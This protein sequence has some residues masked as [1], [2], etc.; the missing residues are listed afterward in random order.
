MKKFKKKK[1]QAV[2]LIICMTVS[3]FVWGGVKQEVYAADAVQAD[4]SGLLGSVNLEG[5][6]Y[7]EIEPGKMQLVEWTNKIPYMSTVEIPETVEFA[8]K[9]Y[10][11]VSIGDRAFYDQ[12]NMAGIIFPDTILSIGESAFESCTRLGQLELPSGLK[13]IGRRAFYYCFYLSDEVSELVIPASVT[14][15]GMSAFSYCIG[16]ESVTILNPDIRY[17]GYE[18]S[19]TSSLVH[20]TLPDG[21]TSLGSLEQGYM[22]SGCKNLTSI[23][24]PESLTTIPKGS[25]KNCAGLTEIS[26]PSSVNSLGASV[27]MGCSGL[28]EVVIPEGVTDINSQ[29]FCQCSEEL[30]VIFPDSVTSVNKWTFWENSAQQQQYSTTITAKCTSREVAA[31]IA[32]IGHKNILLNGEPYELDEFTT[33]QFKFLVVDKENKIVQIEKKAGVSLSGEIVIPKTVEWEGNVYTVTSVASNGFWCADM[34]KIT[35]PD[36][37]TSIGKNAFMSCSNL[38]SINLPDGI[39]RIDQ[40]TFDACPALKDITLPSN[41]KYIDSFAFKECKSLQTIEIPESCTVIDEAA[42][43]GCTGLTEVTL[44]EGLTEIGNNVFRG[45]TGLTGISFP[46]SLE[47]LGTW[48]FSSCTELSEVV[49]NQGLK[50]IG[51]EIFE[52][53][54]KLTGTMVLPDSVTTIQ[55]NAFAKSSLTEVRVGE[56]LTLLES[57]AF[58]NSIRRLTTYSPEVYNLLVRNTNRTGEYAPVL[59]WDGKHD[60]PSGMHAYAEEDV[61]VTE[62][63]TIK[64]GAIVTVKPGVSVTIAEDAALTVEEGGRLEI[65]E[66]ASVTVN[67]KLVN[68]GMVAV[69]GGLTVNGTLANNGMVEGSGQ[70]TVNGT[71]DGAGSFGENMHFAMLL[72][73]EMVADVEDAVYS[74]TPI[75]PEPKVSV[76]LGQ[77]EIAFEKN[78]DFIYSYAKNIIPG[79]ADVTVTPKAG[80]R[81]TGSPVTKHFT[82]HKANQAAPKEWTLTFEENADGKTFTAVITEIEGAEYSFDGETWSEDNKKDDCLPETEYTAYIRMKETETHLAGPAAE[83]TAAA[84]KITQTEITENGKEPA[85]PEIKSLKAEA[86][87]IGVSV[88]I[89]VSPA[90]NADRYEIY[91]VVGTKTTLIK[92]TESGKTIVQDENPQ[93][94]ASY[95]AVAVSKDGKLKS[96][97]GSSKQI[98][99]SKG[100]KIKKVSAVSN[101][102]LVTWKKMKTAKKYVL[103]R[104]TNKNSGYTKVKA[105]GKKKLSYIDKKAKK[106]K[107]YYYKIVVLTKSQPSLMSK[108]SKKI[109]R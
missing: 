22:F 24:L 30:C 46:D 59:L 28:K 3:N 72:T 17:G 102:I 66:D 15:I 67:G 4:A 73:E 11:V 25:F 83:K 14:S 80:G 1:L 92:T 16:L 51:T 26:I 108:S 37:I 75:S 21:M 91:R 90:A 41:L 68:N 69:G 87:K 88:Q 99:L 107:K 94:S 7:K 56:G 86:G 81:L 89:E 57:G 5:V 33:D 8:G 58:P 84:P 40:W 45:C 20:V 76:S 98:T 61:I 47:K 36:T 35:L 38:E 13:E 53:C 105:L 49:L 101:G 29:L 52:G 43:W 109:K 10:T 60:I 71:L 104:S 42:F 18:F 6:V 44:H 55:Q 48:V 23:K 103:Y 39:T 27:F 64:N 54:E 78:T 74:V 85:A 50:E 93:M 2:L 34:T 63:I 79:Q 32:G 97:A 96:K 62:D 65:S 100:T 106:G 9:E 31:L 12:Q 19:Q 95:Y 77:N 70:F 82:I